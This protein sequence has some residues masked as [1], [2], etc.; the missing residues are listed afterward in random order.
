MSGEN[1]AEHHSCSPAGPPRGQLSAVLEVSAA[2]AAPRL[3]CTPFWDCL[4]TA[5][6]GWDRQQCRDSPSS[7]PTQP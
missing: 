2:G 7:E 3:L 1:D 4:A 6:Q 5:E